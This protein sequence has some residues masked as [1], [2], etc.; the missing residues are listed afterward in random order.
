MQL[1]LTFFPQIF[2]NLRLDFHLH[3]KFPPLVPYEILLI[4]VQ[5]DLPLDIQRL[6][7][8][9]LRFL[10]HLSFLV[11]AMSRR[12][13]SSFAFFIVEALGPRIEPVIYDCAVPQRII[14]R[15]FH[16]AARPFDLFEMTHYGVLAHSRSVVGRTWILPVTSGIGAD[17]SEERRVG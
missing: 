13:G 10:N 7:L 8:I 2:L 6:L 9:R 12:L 14:E 17:R 16:V 5:S 4:F 1:P 3:N 11:I 15:M